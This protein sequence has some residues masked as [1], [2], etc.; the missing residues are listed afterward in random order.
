MA[1]TFV[2]IGIAGFL[3]S[4]AF[5][6]T[7]APP[8]RFDVA[9]V[10]VN[11]I[12]NMGGK[13][14]RQQDIASTPGSLTMRNV[15]LR[16]TI[17][18]A[19]DVKD[20]QV[21]GPDWLNSERYDIVAKAADGAK[22]DRLR[23]MLQS[24]LKDRFR[25]TLHRETKELPVYALAIGKNGPKLKESEG[26]GESSMQPGSHGK[27][28]IVFSRTPV[29]QLAELLADGLKRPVIDTTG[30]KGRYDFA[31][32]M[33][34]YIPMDSDGKPPKDLQP[35]DVIFTAVQEQL[36]LKLEAKKGPI[37]ILVIEHAEKV[38]TEN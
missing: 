25:M 11:Q 21:T 31:L 16:T 17:E 36:G 8:E 32:D 1:R 4:A 13:G 19:Y 29:A 30:L 2:S 34:A 33:T 37:E 7:E 27:M 23:L 20:Y 15:N 14:S 5:A 38:P 6:Q 18:W 28:S 9:S 22:D 10:K 24:L 3:A 12:G 26:E 35:E